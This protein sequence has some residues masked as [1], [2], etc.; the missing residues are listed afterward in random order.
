MGNYK[1]NYKNSEMM[2]Q[3]VMNILARDYL[4]NKKNKTIPWMQDYISLLK[5]SVDDYINCGYNVQKYE[6]FISLLEKKL[7]RKINSN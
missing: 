7:L 4:E 3:R 5:W 6:T 2:A 1:K